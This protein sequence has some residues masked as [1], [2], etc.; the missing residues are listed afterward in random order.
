[1]PALLSPS[2]YLVQRSADVIIH[3]SS[4]PTDKCWITLIQHKFK[5]G[6]QITT[7]AQI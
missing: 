1:M 7:T 6:A 5:I 2:F 4:Q 3:L